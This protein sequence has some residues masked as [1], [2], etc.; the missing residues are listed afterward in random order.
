MKLKIA[1]RKYYKLKNSLNKVI[2]KYKNKNN[3]YNKIHTFQQTNLHIILLNS[4]KT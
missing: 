3:S 4:I 2:N 1:I